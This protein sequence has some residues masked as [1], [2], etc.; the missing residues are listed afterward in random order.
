M[1]ALVVV[2]LTLAA[3]GGLLFGSDFVD[4]RLGA[5]ADG[6]LPPLNDAATA[7]ADAVDTVLRHHGGRGQT[8]PARPRTWASAPS[9]TTA[10]VADEPA[11][12]PAPAA[13]AV[14]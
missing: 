12:V 14:S 3:M 4:R 2:V 7:A 9:A 10:A 1:E 11:A 13:S 6:L 5:R 8:G